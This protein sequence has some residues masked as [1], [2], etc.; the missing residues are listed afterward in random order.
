MKIQTFVFVHDEKIILDFAKTGKFKEIENLKYI[1]VSAN[2]CDEVKNIPNVIIARDYADNIEKWNSTLIAYTGWY[3]VWKNNL[4]DTDTEFIN[5]LEYDIILDKNFT[6][7]QNRV[8]TKDTEV[9]SYIPITVNNYWFIQHDEICLPFLNSIQ[10]HHG[11]DFRKYIQTIDP[12]TVVGVTSN[13]SMTPKVFNEFMS[14]MEPVIEDIKEEKMAGHMPERTFPL[15][16]TYNNLNGILL[17][18]VLSHFQ[19]DTHNT[20]NRQGYFEQN[21]EKLINS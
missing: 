10:K 7:I 19:M 9:L 17:E 8:I 13:Q 16:Y 2:P 6:E 18:D 21:Y 20:Q 11:I 12:N 14:W 5:M 15:Y 4:I 1:F 3:L